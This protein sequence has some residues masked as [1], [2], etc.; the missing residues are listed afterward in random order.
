M[1]V[2]IRVEPP[3]V[4]FDRGLRLEFKGEVNSGLSGEEGL[5]GEGVNTCTPMLVGEL[6][7]ELVGVCVIKRG[8]RVVLRPLVGGTGLRVESV[9]EMSNLQSLG[10]RTV[11]SNSDSLLVSSVASSMGQPEA[12]SM[13]SYQL[14]QIITVALLPTVIHTC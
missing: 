10:G 2:E 14:I 13:K 9:V 3:L 11:I 12:I 8:E 6:R 5:R 7:F 1:D 4:V